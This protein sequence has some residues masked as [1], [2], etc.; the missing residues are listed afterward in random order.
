MRDNGGCALPCWWGFE[1]G[2]TPVDEV[3]QFYASFETF[4][5]EQKGVDGRSALYVTFIDPQIEKG[6]QVRHLFRIQ[7]E[8]VIEAEIEVGI[9]ANYQIIP[10][11]EQLGQPNE[12]WLRTIP[13]TYEGVLPVGLRLFF[14]ERGVLVSYAIFGERVGDKVQVCF[15]KNGSTILRL[16][17][18]SIWDPNRNKDFVERANESSELT[19]EGHRPIDEVSNWDA[20]Q[21]YIILTDPTR[22]EC[23]E[24]PSDLWAAP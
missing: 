6:E 15:D 21:F 17:K 1:L 20:E 23:L 19:L 5:T 9:Y 3:R 22:T 8:I 11:L 4:I 2:K 16:W 14:P 12:V 24:T 13:D 7:D 10:V 18:P